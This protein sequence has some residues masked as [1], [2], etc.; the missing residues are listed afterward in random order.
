MK[1]N[2][3]YSSIKSLIVGA[4]FAIGLLATT[5]IAITI[6]TTFNPGDTLTAD[7]LNVLKTAIE[8][9][10]AWAKGDTTAD[11]V[12]IGGDVGIGTT[13]PT[14]KLDVSGT[15]KAPQIYLTRDN[16]PIVFDGLNPYMELGQGGYVGKISS[17]GLLYEN[18]SYLSAYSFYNGTDWYATGNKTSRVTVAGDKI[19]FYTED[20]H[21]ANTTFTPREKMVIDGSGNVG[22]GTTTPQG[23]LDVA[24]SIYQSGSVLHADY[25]F[26]QGYPLESIEEHAEYMWKNQHLKAVA[27]AMVN[28]NGQEV[29]EIGSHRRGILEE[30]EKAHIYIEQLHK[31]NQILEERLVKLESR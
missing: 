25:V 10:P 26:E 31:Q 2:L 5:V 14:Y 19:R 21:G 24:G 30:L 1:K 12:F 8:S 27:K 11:A 6:S 22:I 16:N 28:A 18:Y 7:S 15:I 17:T 23:K 9:M 20:D 29:V 13:S 4:S 3:F